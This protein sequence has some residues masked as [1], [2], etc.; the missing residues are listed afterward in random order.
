MVILTTADFDALTVD[1]TT[2][3]F[4]PN[5]AAIVHSQAH[6]EDV[7]GD[8]DIDLLVHFRTP[9]T[10]IACG[11]ADAT[12]TGETFDGQHIKGSDTITTVGGTCR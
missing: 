3:A 6:P 4:G 12:L 8:G 11:D 1:P 2:L 9:E 10:G 7:N 5:A